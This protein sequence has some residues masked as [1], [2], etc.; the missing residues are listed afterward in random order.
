M[1]TGT[2]I[3]A[4]KRIS[5]LSKGNILLTEKFREKVIN[6]VKTEKKL[7]GE[8]PYYSITEVREEK[9]KNKK[10]IKSFVEKLE[11]DKNY[12]DSK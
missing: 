9:E 6:Q 2:F 12:K 8:T 1:S 5:S 7:S 10:F 4:A 3:S 11:K